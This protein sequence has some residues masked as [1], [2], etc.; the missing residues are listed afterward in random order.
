MRPSKSGLPACR[1]LN[2]SGSGR[3]DHDQGAFSTRFKKGRGMAHASLDLIKVMHDEAEAAQPITG[4]G[5]GYKLFARGLI[6]SMSKNE[7][8]KVYHLLRIAREQ[9]KI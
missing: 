2:S 9:G 4:R 8:Q 1:E 5:I 3:R 6:D 7:M